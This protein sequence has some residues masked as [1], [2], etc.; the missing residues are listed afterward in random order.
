MHAYASDDPLFLAM[1]QRGQD[2]AQVGKFC[3]QC[4]A[5]L[6]FQLG[7]TTDGTN[8]AAL[9]QSEQ[10]LKGVTCFFCHTV[11]A[12]QDTHG[13]ASLND[14]PLHLA[15]DIVMRGGFKDP[16]A[17]KAHP[18]A[19]SA[20][21]DGKQLHSSAFCGTCHDVANAHGSHIE[22][23]FAEWSG[24]LFNDVGGG[25]T[26]ADCHMIKSTGLAATNTQGVFQRTVHDHKFPGVDLALTPAP[27][28]DAGQADLQKQAVE[29][30]LSSELGKALCVQETGSDTSIRVVVD[31]KGAGHNWPSGAAQDRRAWFQVVASANGSTIYQSGVVPMGTDPTALDDGD[32]WLLRDCLLDG[33]GNAVHNFWDAV[34]PSDSNTLPGPVTIDPTSPDFNKTHN[35]QTYPR[36]QSK[37][38][39]ASP[40]KVTLDV[41]ILAFPPALF[42]D[43]FSDPAK[44]G[45]TASDVQSMRANLVPI[46]V[47]P[48]VTWT[49]S[50]AMDPSKGGLV[51]SPTQGTMNYCINDGVNP[52][53][54]SFRAPQHTS[55]ACKP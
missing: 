19:Y 11:D 33:Q 20:L 3:V 7:K 34:L 40:D 55:S 41:Y 23:T 50:A 39:P 22:R 48:T 42:D 49:R 44:V 13:D 8:L 21:H 51:Y 26:C 36:T 2:E 5:P 6:A 29:D 15:N 28:A 1:N 37:T 32:L 30:F 43:L 24:T 54:P 52:S 35:Y 31:N 46:A 17:N 10:F 4:H 27:T 12:I 53:Y 38:L 47:G 16:V 45:L 18:A 14:N 25:N 9:P